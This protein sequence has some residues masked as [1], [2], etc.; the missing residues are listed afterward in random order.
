MAER[1]ELVPFEDRQ[2]MTV[3]NDDGV[4]VVMKPIV[5]SFGLHWH[6]Q[7]ERVHR[8]PVLNE[9]ARVMRVPSAGG[10]QEAM[11]LDLEQFHGWLITLTPDR[12]GDEAKRELIVRYQR[13]AFRVVFEHFHGSLGGATADAR[14]LAQLEHSERTARRRELPGLMDKLKRERTP[15]VRR[16]LHAMIAKACDVE[17][18]EPPAIESIGREAPRAPDI[19]EPFWRAVFALEVAGVAINHSRARGTLALNLRELGEKFAD[20]RMRVTIDKPL[21]DALS[22]SVSPKFVAKNHSVNSVTG[23]TVSCWVFERDDLGDQ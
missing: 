21:R 6:A 8:H 1:F 10:M 16:V 5:E 15:E 17:G 18:I 11:V 22:L 4:F 13:Q 14:V 19:L 9:G 3:R 12:I 20:A 2:I 23:V 7:R